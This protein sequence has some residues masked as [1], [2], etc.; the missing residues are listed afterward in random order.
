MEH[1]SF[2]IGSYVVTFVGIAAYVAYVLR[3]GRRLSA[4]IPDK[5][6]PWT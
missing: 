5:D 6:K 2:I 1:A 4:Q 3:T